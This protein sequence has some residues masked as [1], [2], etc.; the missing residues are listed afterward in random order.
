MKKHIS[1]N[2]ATYSP[3]NYKS[4]VGALTAFLEQEFPQLGG[5]KTRQMLAECINNM[6]TKFYPETN[7]MKPGQI[8]WITV[9]KDEKNSYGKSM[10][11]TQ[12]TNVVLDIIQ[13]HDAMERAEGKKLRDIK[14]EAVVR[15]CKQAFEQ[16]GCL[17]NAEIAI[18]LK[19]SA[20]TVSKYI[21][22]YEMESQTVIPRRGTIHDIGPSLTHKKIIINKLFIEHKSVQQ[23]CRETYHSISSIQRYI[24]AF[25]QI[26]L[27]K[28]KGMNTDET[29]FAVR[30][31]KRLVQEYEKIIDEYKDNSYVLKELIDCDVKIESRFE[32]DV[33]A[34]IDG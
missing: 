28:K 23:V 18:I 5:F 7:H 13:Q 34:M 4:F 33:R 17:T 22:E 19:M 24:V 1:A 31:T 16:N 27:C 6:V 21:K 10:K 11:N 8:S 29:A 14:K 30:R 25:K 32:Q 20:S 12:L 26:L 9:H 15:L 2:Q 3:Q